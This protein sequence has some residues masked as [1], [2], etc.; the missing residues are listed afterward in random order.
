[1]S[2]TFLI[3]SKVNYFEIHRLAIVVRIPVHDM[4]G[5]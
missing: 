5:M 2:A 1:L 3:C 4:H